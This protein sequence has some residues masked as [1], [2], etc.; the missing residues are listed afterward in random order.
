MNWPSAAAVVSLAIRRMHLLP[1]LRAALDK[2]ASVCMLL[3]FVLWLL[4]L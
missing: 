4:D 2:I 1:P 3:A